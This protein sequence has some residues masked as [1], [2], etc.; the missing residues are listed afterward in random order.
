MLFSLLHF[1]ALW[2]VVKTACILDYAKRL[3]T[4][5]LDNELWPVIWT[6]WD[7]LDFPQREDSIDHF[8]EDHVFPV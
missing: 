4:Y 1:S 8:T 3:L 2:N 6:G 5:N 7:V